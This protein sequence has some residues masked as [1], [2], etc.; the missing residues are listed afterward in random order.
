[1]KEI[2]CNKVAAFQASTLLKVNLPTFTV[3]NFINCLGTPVSKNA[4]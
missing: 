4:F 3:Q 2:V 1:M